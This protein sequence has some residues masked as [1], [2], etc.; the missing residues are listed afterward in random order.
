M[1]KN[2]QNIRDIDE[3]LAGSGWGDATRQEI[4]ADASFRR[5]VRVWCDETPADGSAI[6]MDAPPKFEKVQPFLSVRQYF[7]DMGYN[8]PKLIAEDEGQGFL[9]L[10]DLGDASF[11]R[12]ILQKPDCEAELYHSAIDVLSRLYADGT[13][14]LR[15]VNLDN[16]L[17]LPV[18]DAVLLLQESLLLC[19]WLLPALVAED[20][21]AI[22]TQEFKDI[23][24]D[25]IDK[26]DLT[27]QNVV[28]RD[29]HA[30]N[31]FW[32]KGGEGQHQV[33]MIDFQD[34]V[35]GR[36]AYDMVS[37]LEDARRDVSSA[38]VRS[39]IN[40]YI[41]ATGQNMAGFVNEYAF[42]GMQRNAKILGIF[43]RLYM[44]DGKDSYLSYIPRVW[45]WFLYDLENSEL[46]KMKQWQEK[47]L[48][49]GVA[50]IL[51]KPEELRNKLESVKTCQK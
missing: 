22:A 48:P 7:E 19:E 41:A 5:Y 11:S 26:Q 25:I 4:A 39:S 2:K 51:L 45:Q 38:V 44:R 42:Y 17:E 6:L 8:V 29:F 15:V 9:L 16:V 36:A 30:D 10:S 18:Y 31:L 46:A 1:I 14:K 37:L 34:A 12:Q 33:G 20:R 50:E 32:V 43:A 23:L 3:F 35:L 49:H 21:L 47:F 27:P 24:S 40:R 13:G 28:H